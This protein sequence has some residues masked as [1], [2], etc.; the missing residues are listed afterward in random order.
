MTRTKL[1]GGE[2]VPLSEEEL[3][4]LEVRRQEW[5]AIA[6]VDRDPAGS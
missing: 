5:Y 4:E 2:I 3:A 1:F 6:G